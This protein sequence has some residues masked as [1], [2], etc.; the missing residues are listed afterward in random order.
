MF[1]C[2][3]AVFG[4]G[5][6]RNA[7]IVLVFV[8]NVWGM[9]ISSVGEM[10]VFIRNVKKIQVFIRNVQKCSGVHHQYKECFGVPQECWGMFCCSLTVLTCLYVLG[11]SWNP[12]DVG[13]T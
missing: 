4:N 13:S 5:V 1:R 2:S 9:S 8:R 11:E 7:G 3:S 10:F 12:S 6:I